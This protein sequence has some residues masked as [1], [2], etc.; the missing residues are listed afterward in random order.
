[1]QL[2]R[3]SFDLNVPAGRGRPPLLRLATDVRLTVVHIV[4]GGAIACAIVWMTSRRTP[5]PDELEGTVEPAGRF[6]SAR[7]LRQ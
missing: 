1:M 3:F 2:V 4:L 6:G 5:V 7:A